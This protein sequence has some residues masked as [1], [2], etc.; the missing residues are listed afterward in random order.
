[1]SI[2]ENQQK[3]LRML[4]GVDQMLKHVKADSY[5]ASLPKE[6]TVNSIRHVL[7]SLRKRILRGDVDITEPSLS[8]PIIL[9]LVRQT[10][11]QCLK[12]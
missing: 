8:R 9:D 2:S 4:P 10:A 12:V 5:L 6:V 11:S 7:D 1:M 3:F